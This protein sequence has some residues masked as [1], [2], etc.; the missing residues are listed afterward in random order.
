MGELK[1]WLGTASPAFATAGNWSPAVAPV[2]TDLLMFN[3]QA[4][5]GCLTGADAGTNGLTFPK[6]TVTKD[7]RFDLAGSG[8]PLDPTAITEFCCEWGG[9]GDM[10][11]DG[12]ITDGTID[13]YGS[14]KIHSVSAIG[15]SLTLRAGHLNLQSGATITADGT[16]P[17]FIEVAQRGGAASAF[18]EIDSGITLANSD[19]TVK[20]GQFAS[21]ST[22]ARFHVLGGAAYLRGTA[23]ST[24]DI[25]I[26][27]EDGVFF[28]DSTGTLAIVDMIGGKLDATK[29]ARVKTLTTLYMRDLAEVDL[30]A[31]GDHITVTSLWVLGQNSPMFSP[32]TKI[33]V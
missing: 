5:Q 27:V 33:S 22:V 6:V 21:A 18:L 10:Y 23:A 3:D 7:Y 13:C 17:A 28:W 14:G 30:R 19:I 15:S 1:T 4:Q 8:D 16:P 26:V 32:G 25:P 9:D 11:L 12:A 2:D 29:Y 20:S 24:A 31:G